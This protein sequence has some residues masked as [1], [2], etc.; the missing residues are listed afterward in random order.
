[1][2]VPLDLIVDELGFDRET[3]RK[4]ELIGWEA[5]CL[6]PLSGITEVRFAGLAD[7]VARVAESLSDA[8]NFLGERRIV[9][10]HAVMMAVLAGHQTGA[11]RLAHRRRRHRGGQDSSLG[12]EGVECRRVNVRISIAAHGGGS[13]LVV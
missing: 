10:D 4:R 12:G 9:A 7:H 13:M 8:A 5:T 1:M 3:S 6:P 2:V 11:R